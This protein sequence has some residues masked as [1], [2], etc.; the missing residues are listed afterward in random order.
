MKTDNLKTFLYLLMR[1][2]LPTGD[3]AELVQQIES[4]EI[5]QKVYTAKPLADY[6]EQLANRIFSAPIK[7]L[8]DIFSDVT[9]EI[10]MNDPNTCPACRTKFIEITE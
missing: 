2:K 4:T 1:D 10:I 6:A 5:G 7:P 3:V 9:Y 8:N